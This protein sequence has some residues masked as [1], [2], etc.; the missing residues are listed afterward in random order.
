MATTTDTPLPRTAVPLELG[1]TTPL[2]R[3]ADR[4]RDPLELLDPRTRRHLVAVG[5]AGPGR[6]LAIGKDT[7]SPLL[8]LADDATHIGR[9]L[10]AH[11]RIES[12]HVSRLHASITWDGTSTHLLDSRSLN[13][14]WVNGERVVYTVLRPGDTIEIG[15][16]VLRYVERG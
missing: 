2:P 11:L 1:L 6:Y 4:P 5:T 12:H 8:P 3:V 14:T 13:G 9:G 16:L 15:A 7:D 10:S